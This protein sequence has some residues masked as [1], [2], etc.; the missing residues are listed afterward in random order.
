MAKKKKKDK[1]K[2]KPFLKR[3]TKF[4][5]DK[6]IIPKQV[7]KPIRLKKVPAQKALPKVKSAFFR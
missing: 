4:D 2:K 3:I 5:L 6:L 7:E 1:E